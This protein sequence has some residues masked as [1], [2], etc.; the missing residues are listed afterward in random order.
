VQALTITVLPHVHQLAATAGQDPET[1]HSQMRAKAESNLSAALA[2]A[3]DAVTA[4]G[5]LVEGHPGDAIVGV[6]EQ[7]GHDLILMGSRGR[8]I[9]ASTLMG[10]VGTHV[11]QHSTAAV[12]VMHAPCD[13]PPLQAAQAL[14]ESAPESADTT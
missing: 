10:S 11:V 13:R 4:H 2:L 1:L 5:R 9:V 6:A 8:G 3:P 12:L 7:D 14:A